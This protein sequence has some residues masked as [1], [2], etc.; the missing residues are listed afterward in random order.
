MFSPYW[1][2]NIK[3]FQTINKDTHLTC[4]LTT[5]AKRSPQI[6]C[7]HERLNTHILH[8]TAP[9][10][11]YTESTTESQTRTS[12]SLANALFAALPLST[13]GLR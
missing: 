2:G 7:D 3:S 13:T 12:N 1:Q 10:L 11:T 6:I 4:Q 5:Q 9:L 8:P